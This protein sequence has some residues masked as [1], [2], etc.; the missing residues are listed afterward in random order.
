MHQNSLLTHQFACTSITIIPRGH[1]SVTMYQEQGDPTTADVGRFIP[2]SQLL[3]WHRAMQQRFPQI[4]TPDDRLFGTRG[5]QYT[6][7]SEFLTYFYDDPNKPMRCEVAG[8]R[9]NI[10]F[11]NR[12]PMYVVLFGDELSQ[13]PLTSAHEEGGWTFVGGGIDSDDESGEYSEE[14]EEEDAGSE[15]RDESENKSKDQTSSSSQQE[16]SSYSR[17]CIECDAEQCDKSAPAKRCSRCH[18]VYYCSADCQRLHWNVHKPYCIDINEMRKIVVGITK[19]DEGYDVEDVDTNVECGI[20]LEEKAMNPVVIPKCKHV[21]CFTCL[22]TWKNVSSTNKCTCPYCRND[23]V[24][25]RELKMNRVHLNAARAKNKSLSSEQRNEYY[26]SALSDIDDMF[27][28]DEEDLQALF[29]KAGILSDGRNPNA[30]IEVVKK[31]MD[32]NGTRV[33]NSNRMD[34]I[35]DQAQNAMAIGDE[36]EAERIMAS[37]EEE[38]N[39]SNISTIHG[40]FDVPL[41]LAKV[42]EKAG[43]WNESEKTYKGILMEMHSPDIGS[44]IQ[45]RKVWM[46]LCRCFYELGDYERAQAAGSAALEMNRHFPGA[47]KYIALAQKESGDLDAAIVTMNRAVLYETPWSEENMA[48]TKNLFEELK[49]R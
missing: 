23:I 31:I 44:P 24:G 1:N 5:R 47:H 18:T 36:D 30:A 21:F 33:E 4:F 10:E 35:L 2:T 46:G 17:E 13:I 19:G 6:F 32:I 12:E 27:R 7:G 22:E 9:W 26:D 28:D 3:H 34:A 8:S 39:S 37:A 43:E 29:T 40:R 20:C 42:Y 38:M 11:G 15:E 49:S 41:L 14:G 48:E 25:D 45:H 16:S